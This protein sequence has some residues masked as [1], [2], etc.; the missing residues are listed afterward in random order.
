METKKACQ[1][2]ECEK[3]DREKTESEE[4]SLAILIALVPAMTITLF[5]TL[6]LF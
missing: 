4:L 5:S 6:G 3:R 2:P 1:C